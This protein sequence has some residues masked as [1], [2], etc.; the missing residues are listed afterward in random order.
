MERNRT[1]LFTLLSSATWTRTDKSVFSIVILIFLGK[2]FSVIIFCRSI[3]WITSTE[4]IL[5]MAVDTLNYIW[6]HFSEGFSFHL[7]VFVPAKNRLD[8]YSIYQCLTTGHRTSKIAFILSKLFLDIFLETAFTN[9][10]PTLL[11]VSVRIRV[12]RC[13]EFFFTFATSNNFITVVNFHS[14]GI[15]IWGFFFAHHRILF[16]LSLIIAVFV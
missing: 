5:F 13:V 2:N 10:M 14:H 12:I 6:K 1:T 15:S 4:L 7:S 11:N 16:F 3:I 8:L 9:Q